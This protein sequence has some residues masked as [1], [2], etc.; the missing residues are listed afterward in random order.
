MDEIIQELQ[1]KVKSIKDFKVDERSSNGTIR[2]RKNWTAP[3]GGW[4][5]NYWWK[6]LTGAWRPLLKA[7]QN[8]NNN[9]EL[10]STWL[11]TG[12]TLMIPKT[13]KLDVVRDYR[14]ITCL[15]KAYKIYTGL[16]AAYMK[17]HAM[18]NG[19]WDEGQMGGD[20]RCLGNN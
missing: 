11:A 10:I 12:R 5:P 13:T 4:N 2:K 3:G 17:E 9:P 15:N 18:D 16:S 1:S 6:R 7:L 8:L 20:R 14:P 19:I